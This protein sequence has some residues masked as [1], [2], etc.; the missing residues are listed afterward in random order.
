MA[1]QS[2][3]EP[4]PDLEPI[5]PPAGAEPIPASRSVPRRPVIVP[6]EPRK[7]STTILLDHPITVDGVLLDTITARMAT[8]ADISELMIEDDDETSLNLRVRARICG[9]HPDVLAHGLSATDVEKVA[10]ACRPFLPASLLALEEVV[11]AD[12]AAVIG[13]DA[14]G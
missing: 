9:V 6:A 4:D 12:L 1:V 11:L 3:F 10:A 5:K 14:P 13:A 2:A 7:W 8:G